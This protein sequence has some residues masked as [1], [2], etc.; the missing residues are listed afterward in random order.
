[1][2]QAVSGSE[3]EGQ[4]FE[5][6]ENRLR[7]VTKPQGRAFLGHQGSDR[8]AG[9]AGASCAGSWLPKICHPCFGNRRWCIMRLVDLVGKLGSPHGH[10]LFSAPLLYRYL[11]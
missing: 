9:D 8:P 4:P 5:E 2:T 10:S 11:M 1:V 7:R 3:L 6:G